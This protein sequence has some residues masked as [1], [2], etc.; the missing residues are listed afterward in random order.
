MWVFFSVA[1]R[2]R[3]APS[4]NIQLLDKNCWLALNKRSQSKNEAL[5]DSVLFELVG[6]NCNSVKSRILCLRF[7]NIKIIPLNTVLINRF[8]K[9]FCKIM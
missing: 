3:L 1:Y 2:L 4:E 5:L 9:S 8:L 7:I 6:Q